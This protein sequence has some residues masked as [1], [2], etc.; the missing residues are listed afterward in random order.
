MNSLKASNTIESCKSLA[1]HGEVLRTHLFHWIGLASATV[2]GHHEMVAQTGCT[3]PVLEK[4][5]LGH[6]PID[7][8]LVG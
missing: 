6:V 8:G 7:L 2:F 5:L 4:C 1:Q 3:T